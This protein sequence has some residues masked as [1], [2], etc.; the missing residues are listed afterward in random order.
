MYVK[1][2]ASLCALFMVAAAPAPSSEPKDPAP[3]IVT[4]CPATQ[5]PAPTPEPIRVPKKG[6]RGER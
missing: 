5:C 6:E 3:K 1:E 4:P 2:L